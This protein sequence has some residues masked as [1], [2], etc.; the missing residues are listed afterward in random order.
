MV[1]RLLN[2]IDGSAESVPV[3][4]MCNLEDNLIGVF[5]FSH[6]T[7]LPYHQ[8]YSSHIWRTTQHTSNLLKQKNF[9][10]P[11]SQVFTTF[12]I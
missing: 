9:G 2:R 10:L 3:Y 12:T 8:H 7:G 11:V 4:P 1:S 6:Y 5:H